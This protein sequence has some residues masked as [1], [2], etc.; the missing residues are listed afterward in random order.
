[1][2]LGPPR[3]RFTSAPQRWGGFRLMATLRPADRR[4]ATEIL[5]DL[6]PHLDPALPENVYANRW[7]RQKRARSLLAHRDFSGRARP[8]WN[9]HRWFTRFAQVAQT[10]VE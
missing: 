9:E 5:R 3:P 7:V 8:R 1:M 6:A 4:M 2:T 10:W